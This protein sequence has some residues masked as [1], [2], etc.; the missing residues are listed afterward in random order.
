MD[1]QGV[2][3]VLGPFSTFFWIF[4]ILFKNF[5][6]FYPVSVGGNFIIRM[7]MEK[8][9]TPPPHTFYFFEGF[10]KNLEE[11]RRKRKN[12]MNSLKITIVRHPFTCSNN[13]C[14][15]ES[16]HRCSSCLSVS[17][18]STECSKQFWPIH[19]RKCLRETTK[20]QKKRLEEVD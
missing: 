16:K 14:N 5:V 11:S 4:I 9:L 13:Q 3:G 12:S 7:I 18:C 15:N 8:K 10:L 17:Y 6:P 1:F 2:G 19:A 20:L